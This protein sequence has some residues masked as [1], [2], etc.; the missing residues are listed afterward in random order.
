MEAKSQLIGK[1]SEVAKMEGKP[2]R[3][4]ERT[5]CLDGISGSMN[6]S[7]SKL[8]QIVKHR[9]ASILPPTGLQ[10][11]RLSDLRRTMHVLDLLH[12]V[13]SPLHLWYTG[14]LAPFQLESQEYLST[15]LRPSW[16][17]CTQGQ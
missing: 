15:S 9:K 13:S 2:K 1:D 16:F 14:E 12:K 7:L 11:I 8:Q 10:N 5:R 6:T 17:L 4:Q 3:G